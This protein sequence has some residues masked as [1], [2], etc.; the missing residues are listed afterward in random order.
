[1]RNEDFLELEDYLHESNLQ[2]FYLQSAYQ[3]EIE[4]AG[5]MLMQGLPNDAI[6]FE[7]VFF[8]TN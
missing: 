6:P 8:A 1:M 4:E 5:E 7:F 2:A 3:A